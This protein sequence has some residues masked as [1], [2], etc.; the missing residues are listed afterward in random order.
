MLQ[1]EIS[2]ALL[3]NDTFDSYVS[4]MHID[5]S[6]TMNATCKLLDFVKLC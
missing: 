1:E 3:L 6:P 4:Y 5:V 2:V